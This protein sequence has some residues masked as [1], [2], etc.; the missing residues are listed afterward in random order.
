MFADFTCYSFHAVKNLTTA[1]GGAVTWLNRP[2][3][4]NEKI[5]KEFMLLSLH[6][7]TKDALNKNKVGMWEYDI[8]SPA[9][10]CN[11]TDLQAAIGLAQLE[12]YED[13][14]NYR[15]QIVDRYNTVLSEFDVKVLNHKDENHISSGHLYFMRI[16]GIEETARNKIIEEFA[17]KGIATNVHYK[18]L[19]MLTAYKNKGFDIKNYPNAFNAYKNEITLPLYSKLTNEEVEYIA[20]AV[21]DILGEYRV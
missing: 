2:F 6:G 4:D 20:S 10:K 16:N 18:P 11:M 21:K 15:H 12:R 19:P 5:Y 1:E 17:K 13:M 7:Q 3:I 14:L 8:I 9:Y